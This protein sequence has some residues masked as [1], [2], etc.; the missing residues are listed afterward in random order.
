MQTQLQ[1]ALDSITICS[2]YSQSTHG[3][4]QD[5]PEWP[6]AVGFTAIL[7]AALASLATGELKKSSGEA[8]QMTFLG[9][10]KIQRFHLKLGQ[11]IPGQ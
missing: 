2:T 4:T 7:A 11:E 6:A 1:A 9:P 5:E 3:G 8:P 10:G